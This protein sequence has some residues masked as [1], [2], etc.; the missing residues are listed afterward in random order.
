MSNNKNT[1]HIRLWQ[2]SAQASTQNNM[3][4]AVGSAHNHGHMLNLAT[5]FLMLRIDSHK[6]NMLMDCQWILFYVV[7]ILAHVRRAI[8]R[9]EP[10]DISRHPTIVNVPWWF[11]CRSGGYYAAYSIFSI[12]GAYHSEE[13]I[14]GASLRLHSSCLVSSIPIHH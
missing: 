8:N 9:L 7:I 2:L 11:T 6:V 14:N 1:G 10:L 3:Q 4:M 13:E 5:N 12:G